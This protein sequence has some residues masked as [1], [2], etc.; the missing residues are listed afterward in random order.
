MCGF[1]SLQYNAKR[2][3]WR[4]TKL[5]I[6][7][8]V[9]LRYSCFLWGGECGGHPLTGHVFKSLLSW[10][11]ETFAWITNTRISLWPVWRGQHMFVTNDLH[12][13]TS[14]WIS[15]EDISF[16]VIGCSAPNMIDRNR[17]LHWRVAKWDRFIVLCT[18]ISGALM[19]TGWHVQ[20][21]PQSIMSLLVT[22]F[23]LVFMTELI[24]WIGKSV[25]LELVC[26]FHAHQIPAILSI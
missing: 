26:S 9:F 23:L 20:R 21:L 22:I 1:F 8:V 15:K 18:S 24:S 11:I 12:L 4:R 10:H 16:L 14:S 2:R 3:H 19:T 13:I 17:R 25:L 7:T 5:N 6:W